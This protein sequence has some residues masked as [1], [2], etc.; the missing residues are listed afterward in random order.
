MRATLP[1]GVVG[2]PLGARVPW[3]RVG[4]PELWSRE[5]MRAACARRDVQ[6]VYRLLNRA[7]L[8]QRAISRA[9]GQTQ[10][11]VCEIIQG[12]RIVQSVD[13]LE[14][15]ADGLG[16]PRSWW[17]LAHDASAIGYA[18]DVARQVVAVAQ[19]SVGHLAGTVANLSTQ[20]AGLLDL[21]GVDM[22]DAERRLSWSR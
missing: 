18:G 21:L 22:Q 6:M 7:G 14:R 11:E 2:H 10:G 17:G 15:I 1:T 13:L 5:D 16:C 8:S 12:K 20:V 19:D 3:P 4:A 9:C